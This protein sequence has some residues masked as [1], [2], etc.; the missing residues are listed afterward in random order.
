M[1][2][3]EPKYKVGDIVQYKHQYDD[4]IGAMLVDRIIKDDYGRYMYYRDH[5]DSVH[6]FLYEDNI[7]GKIDFDQEEYE[8][9]KKLKEKYG[10][11]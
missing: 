4:G 8:L 2:T 5:S 6:T 7:I 1:K 9:Y 11:L 10:D 3:K